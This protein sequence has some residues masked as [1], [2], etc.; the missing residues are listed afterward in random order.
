M[1]LLCS[2]FKHSFCFKFKFY[3]IFD[4][5][6]FYPEVPHLLLQ[7][8]F[9]CLTKSHHFDVIDWTNL[10]VFWI[11]IFWISDYLTW[12]FGIHASLSCLSMQLSTNLKKNVLQSINQTLKPKFYQT[13]TTKS[14]LQKRQAARVLQY[15]QIE[16][17]QCRNMRHKFLIT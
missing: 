6:K 5:E 16:F 3:K 9:F 4:V 14:K 10:N 1:Q 8:K 12:V 2:A 15:C 17:V 13:L 7:F 11:L